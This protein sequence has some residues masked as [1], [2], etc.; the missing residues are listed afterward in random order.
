VRCTLDGLHKSYCTPESYRGASLR[1]WHNL[2]NGKFQDVT[3][4]AGLYDSSSKSLGIAVLDYNN[5]GWP[6]FLIANDTQPNKLI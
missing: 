4:V 1:L 2:G 6:D 5:D 3:N